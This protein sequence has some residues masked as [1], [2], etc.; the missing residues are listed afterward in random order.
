MELGYLD[1]HEVYEKTGTDDS[2]GSTDEDED[3]NFDR[4]RLPVITARHSSALD[5]L[6][7]RGMHIDP[8]LD[9]RLWFSEEPLGLNVG[10][11]QLVVW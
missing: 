4:R 6:E 9:Y 11:G 7:K 8:S 10:S 2:E 3:E 5:C 1:I